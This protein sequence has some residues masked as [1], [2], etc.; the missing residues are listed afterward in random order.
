MTQASLRRLITLVPQ[1]VYLFATSVR[2]NIRLARPDAIDAE[3]EAA[4]RIAVAHEFILDELRRTATT[5]QVGERGTQL[6]G[7]QRQRIAIARAV[8]K[9]APILA[10][11]RGCCRASTPRANARYRPG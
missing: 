2:D 11:G 10:H 9:D 6:S 7:G 5:P 4:A 1:D 8:L 3:V